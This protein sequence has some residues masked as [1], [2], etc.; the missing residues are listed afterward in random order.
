[1]IFSKNHTLKQHK[2]E[3]KEIEKIYAEL[4]DGYEKAPIILPFD[5]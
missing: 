1:M 3:T 2:M 5:P 4:L